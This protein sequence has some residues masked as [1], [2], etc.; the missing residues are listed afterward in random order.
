VIHSIIIKKQ[1]FEVL[2][3]GLLEI[4][5]DH[6]SPEFGEPSAQKLYGITAFG[7]SR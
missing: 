3:G 4:N 6:S 7:R 5:A 1:L 2:E